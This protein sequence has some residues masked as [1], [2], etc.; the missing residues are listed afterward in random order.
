[1]RFKLNQIKKILGLEPRST[2]TSTSTS[3]SAA[4]DID[5]LIGVVKTLAIKVNYGFTDFTK[6]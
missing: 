2:L 6:V 3:A 1:V 4:D 5:V